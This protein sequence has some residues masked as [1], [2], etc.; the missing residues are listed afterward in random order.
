MVL[1]DLK[2]QFS[3]YADWAEYEHLILLALYY[4]CQ[5]NPDYWIEA[6]WIRDDRMDN[7]DFARKRE[8]NEIIKMSQMDAKSELD[9]KLKKYYI[10]KVCFDKKDF[11]KG[12]YQIKLTRNTDEKEKILMNYLCLYLNKYI[13]DNL[14]NY[15]M[16]TPT[17]EVVLKYLNLCELSTKLFSY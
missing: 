2:Y 1:S 6:E 4:K 13:F 16:I 5:N 9:L 15:K 3:F 11:C 8:I 7:A 14:N 12:I 17:N 10:D